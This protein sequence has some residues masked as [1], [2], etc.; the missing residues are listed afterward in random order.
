MFNVSLDSYFTRLQEEGAQ[1][2]GD[3]SK[4]GHENLS[5]GGESGVLAEGGVD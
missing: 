1:R 4:A 5:A 2:D 3:G